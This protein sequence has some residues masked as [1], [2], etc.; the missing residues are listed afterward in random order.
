MTSGKCPHHWNKTKQGTFI[1][2]HS[3]FNLNLNGCFKK[4]DKPRNNEKR[5]LSIKKAYSEGRHSLKII[6]ELAKELANKDKYYSLGKSEWIKLRN[7]IKERDN[8]TCQSCGCDLHKRKS[9][10]HHIIPFIVSGNN[11]EDN[12]TTLCIPCHA[13]IEYFTR[14]QYGGIQK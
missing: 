7:K 9:N 2:G 4:G 5:K 6:N 1:K 11:S 13:S 10:C 14:L 3:N 12:L 8:W